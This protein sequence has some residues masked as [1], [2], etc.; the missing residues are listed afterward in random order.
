MSRIGKC[1][2]QYC[3]GEILVGSY[4]TSG[5]GNHDGKG[6]CRK[7]YTEYELE[8][9]GKSIWLTLKSQSNTNGGKK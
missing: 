9:K 6:F 3:D 1:K 5:R 8:Y 7:C 2:K 4:N